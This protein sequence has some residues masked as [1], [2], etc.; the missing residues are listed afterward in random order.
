MGELPVGSWDH[1]ESSEEQLRLQF[2]KADVE[3]KE[4]YAAFMA[5]LQTLLGAWTEAAQADT[6]AQL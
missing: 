3:P 4:A 6:Y 5:Q 1:H 2:Q